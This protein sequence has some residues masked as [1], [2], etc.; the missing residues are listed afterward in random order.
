VGGHAVK[1]PTDDFCQSA[2]IDLSGQGIADAYR[3]IVD[4]VVADE[5]VEGTP[6]LETDTLMDT[7][8]ARRAVATKILEF[9]GTLR[10]RPAG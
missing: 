2:G 7:A 6:A 8:E 9:A 1:G 10:S 5:P 3:D 4:G